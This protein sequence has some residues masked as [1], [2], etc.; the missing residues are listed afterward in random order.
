MDPAII[1]ST[2]AALLS[3]YLVKAGEKAAEEVGKKLPQAVC[4]VWDTIMLK[5]RGEAAAKE[6]IK[7]L[8]ANPEDADNL[9]S[10]RK[11]LK[12]LL[13][14]DPTFAADLTGLIESVA[15]GGGETIVITGSGSVAT[16]GGLA[17]GK[18]GIAVRGDIY[19]DIQIIN[20]PNDD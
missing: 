8:V 20:V 17:S 14:S 18:G 4:K 3:S 5:F 2:T 15:G 12:K 1:A 19:G 6:S 10:F 16:K 9:A 11:E 13:I 7:D